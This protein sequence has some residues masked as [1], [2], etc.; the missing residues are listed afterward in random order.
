MA[1]ELAARLGLI[2]TPEEK[3]RKLLEV[4][5]Q[6]KRKGRRRTAATSAAALRKLFPESRVTDPEVS[7]GLLEGGATAGQLIDLARKLAPED[8]DELTKMASDAAL[9]VAQGD[10]SLSESDRQLGTGYLKKKFGFADQP[11]SELPSSLNVAAIRSASR[12][13]KA[14]GE[15]LTL[16]SIAAEIKLSKTLSAPDKTR[17]FNTPDE[18][19]LAL[20]FKEITPQEYAEGIDNLVKTRAAVAAAKGPSSGGTLTNNQSLEQAETTAIARLSTV[21][22]DRASYEPVLNEEQFLGDEGLQVTDPE[23]ASR[24]FRIKGSDDYTAYTPQAQAAVDEANLILTDPIR[25]QALADTIMAARQPTTTLQAARPTETTQPGAPAGPAAPAL[26][27]EELTLEQMLQELN[28]AGFGITA[29]ELRDPAAAQQLRIEYQKWV[30]L[31]RP[32][33]ATK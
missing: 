28:A 9:R 7:L 25:K 5:M 16:E 23:E 11:K 24:Y 26:A 13:A 30:S 21:T 1:P 17:E 33:R 20:T 22:K 31:G 12:K 14:A 29:E 2:D 32:Q 4:E 6:A 18:L 27:Q 15:P 3:A 19:A 10:P 8:P